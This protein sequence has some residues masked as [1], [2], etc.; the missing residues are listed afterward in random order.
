MQAIPHEPAGVAAPAG[1]CV[2]LW[3]PTSAACILAFIM[4]DKS[5]LEA[6]RRAFIPAITAARRSA[7][8]WHGVDLSRVPL[9]MQE[10]V[11]KPDSAPF[12][13]DYAFPDWFILPS[14]AVGFIV[15]WYARF[16]DDKDTFETREAE[17]VRV[18]MAPTDGEVIYAWE[19]GDTI[20]IT[21]SDLML[22]SRHIGVE[23]A[24]LARDG[25]AG[26]YPRSAIDE[27]D[28]LLPVIFQPHGKSASPAS[29][30]ANR[31]LRLL[32]SCLYALWD[33]EAD[34]ERHMISRTRRLAAGIGAAG[35]SYWICSI[36]PR[37][38]T[39]SLPQGGTHASPRLHMRRGHWRTLQSGKKV[40]VREAI[41]GDPDRG[42]VE[43]DYRMGVS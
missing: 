21:H 23:G 22:A 17:R 35:A 11:I 32:S 20:L 7:G 29:A 12:N 25:E 13:T 36:D 42:V 33:R 34:L 15:P 6:L 16:P 8:V 43:K 18:G 24:I 27:F 19:D 3:T 37:K 28:R 30:L 4:A 5:T 14:P 39:R 31:S 9:Y 26:L 1:F 40:F 10:Y 41:V 2:P 38:A